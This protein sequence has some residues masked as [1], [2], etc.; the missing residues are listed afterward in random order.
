MSAW[1]HVLWHE[2]NKIYLRPMTMHTKRCYTFYTSDMALRFPWKEH[3]TWHIKNI[4]RE[5]NKSLFKPSK[6]CF[7]QSSHFGGIFRYHQNRTQIVDNIASF[8][9]WCSWKQVNFM[10]VKAELTISSCFSAWLSS[11]SSDRGSLLPAA[12][13]RR[14][15]VSETFILVG[16]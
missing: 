7:Q 3:E 12:D 6:N 5:L 9:A 10:N 2:T 14:Y 16:L 4:N 1:P 11:Y 13:A 8:L 15:S